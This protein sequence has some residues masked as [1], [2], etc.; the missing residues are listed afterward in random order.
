MIVK[1]MDKSTSD[2]YQRD[3]YTDLSNISNPHWFITKV[4]NE[5]NNDFNKQIV[6]PISQIE[7]TDG[8]NNN[9]KTPMM[10]LP[11]PGDKGCALI[12]SSKRNLLLHYHL[13]EHVNTF[14]LVYKSF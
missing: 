13:S 9:I 5:V 4:V 7:T 3:I 6:P 14:K 11:Y 10:I 12:K 2:N 1:T 8:E